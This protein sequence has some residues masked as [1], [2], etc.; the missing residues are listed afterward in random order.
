[1][2]SNQ[3]QLTNQQLP[4]PLPRASKHELKN[5]IIYAYELIMMD[6][7]SGEVV[8]Q[9]VKKYEVSRRQAD[10]YLYLA[11]K[12]MEEKTVTS[13]ARNISWYKTRKLRLLRDMDPAEKKTAAGVMAASKVLDSIA[14]M[15]G[16]LV[17]N[18]RLS[19]DKDNPILVKETKTVEVNY[20]ELPTPVLEALLA[21]RPANRLIPINAR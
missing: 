19:G 17:T 7:P 13:L 21:N 15:E 18:V 5:R 16:V 9:L 12:S 20:K 11:N 2:D 4:Q 6:L 3:A 1:M 8:Q 10:R 14:K